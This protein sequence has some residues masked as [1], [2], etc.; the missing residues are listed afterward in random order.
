MS[1]FNFQLVFH[2]IEQ[3]LIKSLSKQRYLPHPD[4]NQLS[5]FVPTRIYPAKLQLG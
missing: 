3:L 1:S 5:V 2:S 4:A